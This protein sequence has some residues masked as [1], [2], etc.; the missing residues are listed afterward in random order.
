MWGQ[1][2]PLLSCDGPCLEKIWSVGAVGGHWC[3]AD[4]PSH[5]H[6]EES[7][8]SGLAP[9]LGHFSVSDVDRA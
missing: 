8:V 3:A 7:S 6:S 1:I 9:G 4:P 5:V 2:C